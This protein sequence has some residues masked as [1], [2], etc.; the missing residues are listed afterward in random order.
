MDGEKQQRPL[1]RLTQ[2]RREKFL[3]VLGQ[4]GNRRMAAEAVGFEPRLM[5]QRRGY[6]ALLDRQWIEALDQADRRL[7]GIER[8]YDEAAD[9]APMVIK[10]GRGGRLMMQRAGEK[11]W[12][13]A[14]ED[15]FFATLAMC[16]NIAAS[17]RAVGF[18]KSCIDQR[19]RKW[20]DFAQ[21]MEETLDD[22]EVEIEFRVA[23]EVRGKRAGARAEGEIA[24]EAGP[25]DMDAAMRFLKWR[26]EKK[27]GRGRRGRV[28]Q[29]P[30]IEAVTEKIVKRVEAIKRHRGRGGLPPAPEAREGDG[31]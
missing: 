13:R 20:P 28:P 23:A 17:A 21:R 10:R 9:G 25:L 16:G 18:S 14:V 2:A 27:A 4:T 6:D 11:R 26:Q 8:P 12:S 29:P 5:D 7:A 30:S 1:R 15:R 31:T 22:A 24:I 3:E 19:R